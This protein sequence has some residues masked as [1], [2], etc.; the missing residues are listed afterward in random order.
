[1][2]SRMIAIEGLDGAGTETQSKLLLDYLKEKDILAERI[3]YPDYSKPIGKLIHEYLHNKFDFPPDVQAILYAADMVKDRDKINKW[4]K[5]GKTIILDRYI[6]ST[7]AY[8]GF[9]GF[10]VEK[11]INLAELFTL[12]KPDIIIYLKVSAEISIERKL[13]EKPELDRNE[14]DKEFLEKLAR[15]YL[16]LAKKNVFGKWVVVDGEKSREE[17]FE[18]VRKAL[19]L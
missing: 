15:F 10:P 5:E 9:R 11:I 1:M 14:T 7:I 12:P 13:K 18:E 3:C 6:T 16:E 4:L 2:K 8:Q 19:E 17:V